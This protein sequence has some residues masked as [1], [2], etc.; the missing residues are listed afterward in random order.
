MREFGFNFVEKLSPVSMIILKH[1][2]SKL[3]KSLCCNIVADIEY[4]LDQIQIENHKQNV[5]EQA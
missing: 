3:I 1:Q 4:I 2:Y 5:Q